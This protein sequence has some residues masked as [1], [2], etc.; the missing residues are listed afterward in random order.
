VTYSVSISRYFSETSNSDESQFFVNLSV[1]LGSF[2]HSN[3]SADGARPLFDMASMNYS[4]SSDKS[5]GLTSS[6]SG[7][8]HS[9][10]N[11]NYDVNYGLNLN[12]SNPGDRES[13]KLYGIGGYVNTNARYGQLS[14]SVSTDNAD[15]RQASLSYSGGLIAHSGGITL[16]PEINLSA[17]MALVEAKGATDAYITNSNHAF[18]NDSGYGVSST[19]TPYRNN[20]VSLDTLSMTG[21]AELKNTAQE[22]VPYDG[23][24]VKINFDADSR[25]SV[26]FYVK[27]AGVASADAQEIPL[28]AEVYDDKGNYLGTAGQNGLLITRGAPASG[29]LLIKWGEKAEESCHVTYTIPEHPELIAKVP[30]IKDKVCH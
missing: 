25:K 22:V 6:L 15:S 1:P 8:S 11:E 3:A 16:A 10:R 24:L 12:Y 20:S 2:L 18:I 30:V 9:D 7:S 19:L 4:R 26:W 28:G 5:S 23:V 27:R 17:P 13:E 14:A 21:D 29:T